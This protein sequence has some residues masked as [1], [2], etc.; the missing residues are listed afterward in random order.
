M[1][2]DKNGWH[3]VGPSEKWK[4]P[5]CNKWSGYADWLETFV[6]CDDCGEHD[7]RIC[8]KCDAVFDIVWGSK[9]IA[10]AT[11]GV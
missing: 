10:K 5:E 9:R 6:E 8:P 4:C 7:A 11:F 3:H 2:E 1:Q